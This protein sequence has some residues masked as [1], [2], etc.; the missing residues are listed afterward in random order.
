MSRPR[1]EPVVA[2]VALGAAYA[3]FSFLLHRAGV[4]P[5]AVWLPIDPARYYLAQTF[6]VAPLFLILT[7]L[8]VYL[9]RLLAGGGRRVSFRASFERLASAYAWPILLLFVVPDVS[10]FLAAGHAALAKAM[11]FYGPLAP[12]AIVVLTTLRARSLFGCGAARAAAASFVALIAQ[13]VV[14][15]VALR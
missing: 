11:R 1:R 3:A 15:A 7:A 10:V 5:R 12:I 13:G 9:V 2:I 8:Y 4:S 6:F 14:G